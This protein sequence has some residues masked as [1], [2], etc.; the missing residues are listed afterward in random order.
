MEKYTTILCWAFWSISI[1]NPLVIILGLGFIRETY[2]A[3]ILQRKAA[4]I[5]TST[6][7]TCLCASHNT[8]NNLRNKLSVAL[9]RPFRLPFKVRDG[10]RGL[11]LFVAT[12]TLSIVY[13]RIPN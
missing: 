2:P 7:N 12:A 4:A 6:G 3:V 1:T 8:A 11:S 13:I 9:T 5:Y 10:S